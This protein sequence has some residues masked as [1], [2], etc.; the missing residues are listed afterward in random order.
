MTEAKRSPWQCG[1]QERCFFGFMV[2]LKSFNL[3]QGLATASTNTLRIRQLEE[4]KD[5]AH[6]RWGS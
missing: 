3:G 1:V 2:A 6:E 5:Q 4:L